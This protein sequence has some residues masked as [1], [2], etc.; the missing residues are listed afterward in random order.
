MAHSVPFKSITAVVDTGSYPRGI[1]KD[2]S[3][4]TSFSNNVS[5]VNG[6]YGKNSC[7][8]GA[9]RLWVPV[10]TPSFSFAWKCLE[11]PDQLFEPTSAENLWSTHDAFVHGG[12]RHGF[13]DNKTLM[14]PDGS[15]CPMDP[16]AQAGYRVHLV[17]G[18]DGGPPPLSMIPKHFTHFSQSGPRGSASTNSA[19]LGSTLSEKD[20]VEDVFNESQPQILSKSEL[21]AWRLMGFPFNRQWKAAVTQTT[22]HGLELK[23]NQ[24]PSSVNMFTEPKVLLARMRCLPFHRSLSRLASAVGHLIWI[25]FHGPLVR[26]RIHQFVGHFSIIDDYSRY[27][28]MFAVHNFTAQTAATCVTRFKAI[29]T[30]LLKTGS[31]HSL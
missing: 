5:S 26:S 14:F 4:F 2:L 1:Y 30:T 11:A 23:K 8:M 16:D 25:D 27:G 6:L 12:V 9:A 28:L 17:V 31:T 24:I 7:S 13:D 29:L 21:R 10:I 15:F 20:P 22:E 19:Y 18:G 3:V